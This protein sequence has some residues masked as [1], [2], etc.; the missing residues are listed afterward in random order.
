MWE[1]LYSRTLP[2]HSHTPS[3]TRSRVT[4][5]VKHRHVLCRRSPLNEREGRRFPIKDARL[6]LSKVD[7]LYYFT[8]LTI[9]MIRDISVFWGTDIFFEE[10][11]ISYHDH[12]RGINWTLWP[13]DLTAY[14][15]R[16]RKCQLNHYNLSY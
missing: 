10:P 1:H 2:T 9:T 11:C 4:C 7:I 5:C 3:L 12:F 14:W 15:W 6:L 8:F 16:T 13:L